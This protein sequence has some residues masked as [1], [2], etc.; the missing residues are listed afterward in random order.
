MRITSTFNKFAKKNPNKPA[1]VTENEVVSYREWNELVQQTATAFFS[2]VSVYKRV[3]LFLPNNRLF[4]QVFAGASFAGWTSIVG[5]M[6]WKEQEI[7]ERLVQTNPDLIIADEKMKQ[8][9]D[10]L[11]LRVIYSGEIEKWIH[12]GKDLP[13]VEAE[14]D[15]PFYI[16]FTSGSTGKPK[17]FVRSHTSWVE[18]FLCN[19]V[20]LGMTEDEHVLIPGSFVN[21]TF[22]YGA[23]STLFLGGTIYVLAKFSPARFMDFLLPYPITTVYVVPTMLQGLLTEDCRDVQKVAFISTGAKW[24]PQTKEQMRSHFPNARFYEFYGTSELS[25]VTVLKSSEQKQHA[26]SVGRPFHN[27]EICIRGKNGPVPPGEEGLL[28]VKSKMLFDGYIDNEEETK[29]VLQGEWATVYDMAKMDEEG[30]LYILGRQNDMILY[31]GT[32]IYPQEIEEALK[33][34]PGVEEAVVFGIKDEHWG[35]KPV[36]CI[37]GDVS[38]SSVKH[39]CL[40]TLAAYKIPRAFRKVENFLYTTG[41][42]ISR[43]E[44]RR[45]FEQGVLK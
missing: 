4:L 1:I 31:G 13:M 2:E 40:Q 7:K 12:S 34:C 38:I 44:L 28:Y 17:A 32:N 20:D 36:A 37:K 19:Q 9:L 14:T 11:P 23:L 25:F 8:T 22:L 29:K 16:G 24:L 35:E 10:K 3:A 43:R 33:K 41:G 27:V 45:L 5:D 18:S 42:K 15:A 39:Y 6:R 30:F 26:A 21:S